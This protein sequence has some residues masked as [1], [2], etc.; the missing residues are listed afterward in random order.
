MFGRYAPEVERFIKFAITGALA[1]VIDFVTVNILLATI[2]PPVGVA[3][4]TNVLIA[5]SFAYVTGVIFSFW[6]NRLWI[7]P[8]TAPPHIWKQFLQFFL[9]YLI[10][11]GIRVVVI[12][13]VYP[14]WADTVYTMFFNA[15]ASRVT[16][17]HLG[18][19]LAQATAIGVTL[20]WNFFAN[21][22]WT[23]GDVE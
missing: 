9:I 17:N 14:V 16:A 8:E 5:S 13:L 4:S 23:F 15:S 11:L 12:S 2:F 22:Y 20:L 6:V 19:N 10:A 18:A 3:E 1:T 7:Y 21:R